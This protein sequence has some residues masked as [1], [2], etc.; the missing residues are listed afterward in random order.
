MLAL[1]TYFEAPTL[2]DL[3]S[4]QPPA[5]VSVLLLGQD[6]FMDGL[7]SGLY[8]YVALS[9]ATPNDNSV[10][11]SNYGGNWIKVLG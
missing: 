6:S 8:Y 5:S 3:K 10:I 11:A 2:A 7:L 9:T 4:F 1:G